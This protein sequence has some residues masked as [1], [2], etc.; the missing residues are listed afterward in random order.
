MI[1]FGKILK[2]SFEILWNYKVLWVFGLLLALTTGGGGGNGGGNSSSRYDFDQENDGNG[3]RGF[4]FGPADPA[5]GDFGR[6]LEQDVVPLFTQPEQ[7]IGTFI[8]IGAA[9]FLL[10][11]I[12]SVL[13]ALIRYPSE[14][15]VM[16]MVDEYEQTGAKMGFRQGWKLGWSRR[17]FR[18]WL[19]DLIISLPG[20]LF[21]LILLGA[22]ILV[23]SSIQDAS[24]GRLFASLGASLIF[25]IPFFLVFVVLM[26]FLGLLRN[27]FARAAALEEAG[28]GASFRRGW[29]MFKQNWKSVG[30]MW[31]ILLG[32]GILYGIA[33][34]LAFFLLI[35]AYII[36]VVPAVI[37]AAIPG[38]IALGIASL[39][40]T[41]PLT[42]IIAALA[43][44][45]F[46]LTV[47]FAPL[48]LLQGW[49]LVYDSNVWTLTYQELVHLEETRI[50]PD[51]AEH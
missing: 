46:F 9:F 47:V 35:P 31:L 17:A 51:R 10:I 8:W 49:Y 50:L 15:A 29:G 34:I 20:L 24:P 42:W 37:V 21:V 13:V 33:A 6:W 19:I 41:S 5:M 36:L 16:R 48:A 12:I 23:F 18:L 38:L 27:F 40:T 32:I 43:A 28:V 3:F 30:L 44:L 45:P 14:T 26:I 7:H 2:R 1:D 4:D 39:F 25:F 11:V 22:G